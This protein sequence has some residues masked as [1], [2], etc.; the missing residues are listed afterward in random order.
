MERDELSDNAQWWTTINANNI[1][2]NGLLHG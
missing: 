2:E 1:T